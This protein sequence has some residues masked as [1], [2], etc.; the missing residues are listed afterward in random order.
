MNY[1][2]S[3][4]FKKPL[5]SF[6]DSICALTIA[7][8]D[9]EFLENIESGEEFFNEQINAMMKE[10]TSNTFI[11]IGI[12]VGT[13]ICGWVQGTILMIVSTR[14]TN[15]LRIKVPVKALVIL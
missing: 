15:R 4:T 3:V 11:F 1:F 8:M 2:L 5:T 12:G 14:I 10:M 9:P 7:T 6:N 13:W